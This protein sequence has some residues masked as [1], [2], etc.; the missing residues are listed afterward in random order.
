MIR[1]LIFDCFGVLI[2]EGFD[3]TYQQAGGD[4]SRDRGFINDTL[5]K[6]NLGQIKDN[7]FHKAMADKLKVTMARWQQIIRD[8]EQVNVELLAY[9]GTIHAHYKT[10]I[11]SNAN[12]GVLDQKIGKECLEQLFDE[13]IVSA[14][15]GMIKPDIRMYQLTIDR[16]G[17]SANQCIYIDDRESFVQVADSIGMLG[18][19]Y[20]NTQQIKS[21]IAA[22]LV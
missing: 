4:P 15:V 7:Q 13:V 5:K 14:D 2:G 8:A 9:I 11:L 22:R 17:V 20:H 1:A 18:L 16:L 12:Y 10:A 21:A 19:V 6:A 3:S